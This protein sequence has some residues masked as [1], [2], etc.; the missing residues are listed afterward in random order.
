MANVMNNGQGPS[1]RGEYLTPEEVTGTSD[2]LDLLK[3][4]HFRLRHVCALLDAAAGLPSK[5]PGDIEHVRQFLAGE[6]ATHIADE[7]EDLFPLLRERCAP[8][9]EIA[10]MIALL[11]QDHLRQI[12]ASGDCL[13]ILED[14]GAA[15]QTLT[16]DQSET[17]RKFARAKRKH[18]SLENAIL[19]PLARARLKPS[20]LTGM[21]HSMRKR[22]G[23]GPQAEG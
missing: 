16:G 9:D 5:E 14:I 17:L 19:M 1:A 21:L 2:P 3:G 8:E 15:G 23:L 12:E 6:L 18:L 22:R 4:D 13:A 10:R 11:E 7:E 20:D